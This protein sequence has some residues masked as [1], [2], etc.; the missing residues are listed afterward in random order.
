VFF[1]FPRV[2]FLLF[3]LSPRLFPGVFFRTPPPSRF[4]WLRL[5]RIFCVLLMHRLRGM[6][7]QFCQTLTYHPFFCMSPLFSFQNPLRV[8][9]PTPISSDPPA[10]TPISLRTPSNPFFVFLSF[11]PA[12]FLYARSPARTGTVQAGP[13]AEP[14]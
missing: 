5:Y 7:H 3:S 2:Y 1:E 11:L 8:G 10:H 6:L 14:C 4:F 13:R 12:P 9:L